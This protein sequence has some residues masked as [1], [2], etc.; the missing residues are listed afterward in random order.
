MRSNNNLESVLFPFFLH[1]LWPDLVLVV[2]PIMNHGKRKVHQRTFHDF[3]LNLSFNVTNVS[4]PPI[5]FIG[6]TRSQ[7]PLLVSAMLLWRFHEKI[8][9][10]LHR[11]WGVTSRTRFPPVLQQSVDSEQRKKY[12]RELEDRIRHRVHL[13]SECEFFS[14]KT[15]LIRQPHCQLSL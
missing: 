6:E 14:H 12:T 2:V 5:I 10:N 8:F 3:D 15:F 9:R 4:I 13:L 1:N 7:P 11:R